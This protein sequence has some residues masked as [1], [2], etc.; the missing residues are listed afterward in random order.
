MAKQQEQKSGSARAA[1]FGALL[2]PNA[3]VFIASFCVM[4]IELV[5]GRVIARYLGSSIY[6]WTSV[7]GIVLAGLALG[8]YVGGRLADRLPARR[9]LGSL[10][11]AASA[12]A[13]LI[14]LVDEPVGNLSWLWSL[15]WPTRVASH[16][17]LLFFLPSCVLGTISPVVAKLALDLGYQPGR[18]I[19]GIYAWGT[20]GSILGTFL[21]GFYLVGWFGT[22]MI[23]WCVAGVLAL[24][25]ILY[26]A[27]ALEVWIWGIVLAI[28]AAISGASW[29][30]AVT[31]GEA[32]G[33]RSPSSD[34]LLF[35][36]ESQYSHVRVIQVKKDPDVRYM[37]L[38]LLLHSQVEMASP[39]ILHYAYERVYAAITKRLSPGK[40]RIDTLMIGGG[41]YVFPRFLEANWPGSRTQVVEIDPVVTEAA[42]A[43]LGL[44]RD[45]PIEIFHEDGR[46]MIE[47]LDRR[48]RAG[49]S[50]PLYD[51][52]YVDVFDDYLVPYQLTTLEFVTKVAALLEPDGGYLMNLI[53]LRHRGQF[54]GAVVNTLR[55]VFPHVYVFT[56]TEQT[57]AN[58]NTF[59]VAG[60]RRALDTRNLGS[61]YC[62]TCKVVT[63][64][65][66]RLAELERA[67]QG[68]VLTDEYAPVEILLAPVALE[69]SRQRGE[70]AWIE[71]IAE[72]L[73]EGDTKSA[74]DQITAALEKYPDRPQLLYQ[75]GRLRKQQNRA[76][77]AAQ[78][79]ARALESAPN[80]TGALGELGELLTGMNRGEGAVA[81]YQRL[82]ALRPDDA[83]THYN[84]GV[85]LM[86]LERYEAAG[87][88][89]RQAA[90]LDPG[91]SATYNNW[92]ATL[93]A[94]KRFAEAIVRFSDAL[95]LEPELAPALIGRGSARHELHDF[96][97]ALVDFLLASSIEPESAA[98]HVRR[99]AV[100]DALGRFGEAEQAV[101]TALELAPGDPQAELLLRH[102]RK[103]R[104]G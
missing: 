38:D 39:T 44:A 78:S 62:P 68:L 64:S 88:S 26:A 8:N 28:L 80:H 53:D 103:R 31:T 75:Q 72:A 48:R 92:G 16:V 85:A 69:S 49:E 25:G 22:S 20:V 98:P 6:T 65:P 59:I 4:V 67:S 45:T 61:G 94:R 89:F 97:G 101:E 27:R 86:R 57:E 5:A 87:E 74:E 102:I 93:F 104:G 54:L 91:F 47:R 56:E 7:I 43:A 3:T 13:T 10:F 2:A 58:R 36:Q 46:A 19:G 66:L 77:E 82:V 60:L 70:S 79:F 63:L 14:T 17:A 24:M 33:L 21:T 55:A 18:T 15:P 42:M 51:F 1:G 23:L 30:W 11:I 71:R 90:G 84:H 41:G 9:A 76:L 83:R 73:R 35:D 50:V 40:Q 32:L 81:A 52:I 34:Q 29:S 12:S 96:E 99:G 37:H 100:L 95:R